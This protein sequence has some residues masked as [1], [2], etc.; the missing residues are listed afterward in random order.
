MTSELTVAN[1]AGLLASAGPQGVP[2]LVVVEGE[3]TVRRYVC[4]VQSPSFLG[5]TKHAGTTGL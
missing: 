3:R 5:Y 1:Q 4:M 2:A